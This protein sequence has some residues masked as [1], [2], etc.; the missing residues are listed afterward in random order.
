MKFCIHTGLSS[1]TGRHQICIAHAKHHKRR[2]FHQ[3]VS[4]ANRYATHL[5]KFLNQ[6]DKGLPAGNDYPDISPKAILY[7]S[8]DKIV[9]PRAFTGASD[10]TMAL[11]FDF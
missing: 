7:L 11:L 2:T 4:N 8:L 10:A 6:F 3:T 5:I 1:T 9:S